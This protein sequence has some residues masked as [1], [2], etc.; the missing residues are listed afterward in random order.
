MVGKFFGIPQKLGMGPWKEA[1]KK[2][3]LRFVAP[4]DSL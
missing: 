2:K 4:L 3:N 1:L